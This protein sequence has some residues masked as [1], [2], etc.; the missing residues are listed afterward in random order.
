MSECFETIRVTTSESSW[1]SSIVKVI[2]VPI[3]DSCDP[4]SKQHKRS[5][6][7]SGDCYINTQDVTIGVFANGSFQR[8][9]KFG[10]PR[11]CWVIVVYAWWVVKLRS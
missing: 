1:H 4:N 9:K 8:K 7:A 11:V 10:D 5:I 6:S 2:K 3:K